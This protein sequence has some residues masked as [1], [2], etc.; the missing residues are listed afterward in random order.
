MKIEFS[1]CLVLLQTVIIMIKLYK[2][3]GKYLCI[4][5]TLII[6][7]L[8]FWLWFL[9]MHPNFWWFCHLSPISQTQGVS[10]KLSLCL[11]EWNVQKYLFNIF[12]FIMKQSFICLSL[13]DYGQLKSLK[14]LKSG[15]NNSLKTRSNF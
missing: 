8:F 3:D 9:T 1:F 5:E 14:F 13:A 10:E 4:I 15:N 7:S 12:T 6:S 2:Q 11:K